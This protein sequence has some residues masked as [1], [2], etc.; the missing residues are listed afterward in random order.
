[1]T[2]A[3]LS[4]NAAA[5]PSPQAR[6]AAPSD[7][8]TFLRMLTAQ[9]Q[10]QDP[11]N[12]MDSSDYAVQLATFSGVEQ[13]QRTNQLLESLG[14]QFGVMNLAQLAGWVGKEA[15]VAAPAWVDGAPVT[16]SPN[17]AALADRAV[18][19]V[20]DAAG[21]L[22][23]R[24]DIPLI[25]GPMDWAGTDMAGDPLPAGAYSFSLESY[26]NGDLLNTRPVEVYAPITEARGGPNGTM[27]VLRGGIEVLAAD[28][29]ALRGGV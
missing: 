4:A 2:I 24:E 28:V 20:R 18:L 17:P 7:Y 3:P 27:L 5:T 22:I 16:L 12:P 9:L 21:S 26:S 6:S 11:L 15:R 8:T 23:S 25:A 10:N 29:T 1:M 19:V 13:Q 14:S